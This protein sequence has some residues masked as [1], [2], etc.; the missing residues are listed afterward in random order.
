MSLPTSTKAI[1][2]HKDASGNKE[3]F[4]DA[5]VAS[6][7]VPAL[8]SGQV[9]VKL[10]A[11]AF[12]R[13]DLWLRMGMYPGLAFD[14]VMGS[15]GVGQV[16]AAA[17]PK[18]EL[19]HKRVFFL[20]MKGWEDDPDAPE[21][22]DAFAVVG[23]VKFAEYG[24]FAEYV[25]VD[26]NQV[27]LA[28]EFIDDL[29]LAA[30]P[31]GGLT[32]WRAT[33]VN[34]RVSSGQTVLVTGAGGGVAIVAIQLCIAQGANVYVTTGSADKIKKAV[35]LGA[36]GGVNYKDADW[37]AQ[38]AD[39]LKK[40][41]IKKL[42]VVIDSAGGE[43]LMAQVGKV[44]K[45][46]GIVVC[47][48]M[49]AGKQINVTMREVMRNQRLVGSTM[50]SKADLKNATAFL[51]KHR[52]IPAV[53]HVLYGLDG[54]LEAFEIMKQGEGFGKVVVDISGGKASL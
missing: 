45:A 9:L 28:P 8:Q 27:L 35:D 51:E 19:L 23:G 2:L 42:D 43:Q 54:A 33:M 34:G 1:V 53:S 14:K 29:H 50:G 47:Y 37:P 39:L 40:D 25:V 7:P 17:D 48:G 11:L 30:W 18:D 46:G 15:D 22:G 36:K 6:I 16:I 38:L 44:L 10:S 31:L 3:V 41:G 4:H 13:R 49:T 21:A 20:P 52:I 24:T 12:N 5:V 32:A 26:R